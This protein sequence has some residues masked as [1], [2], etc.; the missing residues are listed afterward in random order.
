MQ[1]ATMSRRDSTSA[2]RRN[3]VRVVGS[4][5]GRPIVLA[6]G[7]GCDSSVWG[8]V[9]PALGAEHPVVLFDAVGAGDSDPG[10]YDPGR[11]STLDG[12]AEDLLDILDAL[13]L[14]DAVVVGHSVAASIAVLAAP[15]AAGRIGALAL[16]APNPRFIDDPATGYRG[17]FS[18]ADID[19]LLDTLTHNYG[20]W[21]AAM[22]PAIMA[23]PERP[24]LSEQFVD[25]LCRM[26]PAIAARFAAVTFRAD[27][28]DA[29]SAVDVPALVLQCTDDV[30]AAIEVGEYVQRALPRGELVVLRAT[31]HCPHLSAPRET[32]A[33]ILDWAARA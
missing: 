6:H 2:L 7:Y 8:S 5:A 30:L 13:D 28:R 32:A 16:L 31:G 19:G 12:Y 23:N 15:R 9:V 1:A 22:A 11:Y 10:A 27:C 17:G 24:E 3:N 33:A 18:R 20:G 14:H 26:E 25:Q 29:L 21:A 4:G